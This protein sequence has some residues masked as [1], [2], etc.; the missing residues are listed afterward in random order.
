MMV[1]RTYLF[2]ILAGLILLLSTGLLFTNL[3]L[4]I[5]RVPPGSLGMEESIFPVDSSKQKPVVHIG[6]I[7]RYAPYL[8]YEG[9]QPIMDYLTDNSEYTYSLRLSSSYQDAA[10]KLLNGDV[11]ASFFGTQIY[12]D[13][14]ESADIV[15]ILAPLSED[16][17]P[18]VHSVLITGED[19]PIRTIRDL[20]G[21]SLALPSQRSFSGQWGMVYL[22]K[23]NRL[24]SAELGKVQH[25]AYH[26]T[27]I[28]KVLRG[29]YDAG[30][31]KDR[32]ADE[33]LDKGI[34]IIASSPP[35]P[36]APIV[37]RRGTHDPAVVKMKDLLLRLNPADQHDK[38]I[39]ASWDPEFAYGFA[40]IT[41][42]MYSQA[43]VLLED[44]TEEAE[45]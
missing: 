26:Q 18:F 36:S 44:S 6:V 9:Y 31:V 24:A 13:M 42:E 11:A 25:F 28:Y 16:G 19:S 15:P 38:E 3:L 30:V 45:E 2:L 8:I 27:V 7:S 34:R 4:D 17:T 5:E 37:T 1:K 12:L 23:S 29:E 41:A 10:D 39:L 40:E 35:F 32:V 21:K 43:Q 33:F 20:A 22:I 14:A